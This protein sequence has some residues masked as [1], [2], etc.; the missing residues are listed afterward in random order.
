MILVGV[1]LKLH[2]IILIELKDIQTSCY[3]FHHA[4]AMGQNPIYASPLR[5]SELAEIYSFSPK[6]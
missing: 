5:G 2:I 3:V 1:A 4:F 6:M